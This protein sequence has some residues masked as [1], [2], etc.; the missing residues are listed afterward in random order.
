M[1]IASITVIDEG[2]EIAFIDD[3]QFEYEGIHEISGD[4]AQ[5]IDWVRVNKAQVTGS[6][7][8]LNVTHLHTNWTTEYRIADHVKVIVYED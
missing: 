8:V 7:I 4:E 6:L 3:L 2:D 5:T 1:Y